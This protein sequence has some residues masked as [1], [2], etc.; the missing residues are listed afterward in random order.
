MSLSEGSSSNLYAMPI[1][2]GSPT[3]LTDDQ[4]I[5]TSPC[6]SPDG[7]QIT[8]E[9][10]RGGNQQIYVMGAGRRR[11]QAHLVRR[12]TV[13]DAGVVAAGRLHRLHQ[14]ELAASSASAL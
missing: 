3:Q 8:F 14:A 2:G 11:R 5:D 12:R 9:S 10:D 6:Y 1:G 4:S 7:S 13:F